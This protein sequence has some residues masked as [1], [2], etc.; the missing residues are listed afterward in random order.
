M[1]AGVVNFPFNAKS[2]QIRNFRPKHDVDSTKSVTDSIKSAPDATK[3]VTKSIESAPDSTKSATESIESAS[4]PAKSVMD[5]IGSASDSTKSAPDSIESTQ[6]FAGQDTFS[7]RRVSKVATRRRA[8]AGGGKLE[9]IIFLSAV[10]PSNPVWR[11]GFPPC[12]K[13]IS[14]ADI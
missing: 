14:D 11:T 10:F 5:S 8:A 3:S 6:D 1:A 13:I 4:D 12:V 2:R 9:I 7:M